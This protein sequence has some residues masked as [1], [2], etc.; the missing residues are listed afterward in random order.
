M[1]QTSKFDQLTPAAALEKL[2]KNPRVRDIRLVVSADCCPVCAAQEGT[3]A[4]D[5]V[6]A[7]PVQGCSHPQGCR[8]FYEPMLKELYP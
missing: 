1:Q 5:Q 7:V 6:P 8:C 4:K 2:Q 3:Y